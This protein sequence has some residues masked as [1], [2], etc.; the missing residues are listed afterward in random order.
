MNRTV[1]YWNSISLPFRSLI[2]ASGW[3][4]SPQPESCCCCC[5]SRRR[6]GLSLCTHSSWLPPSA[7]RLFL[8]PPL[9]EKPERL[10]RARE[11]VEGARLFRLHAP[12]PLSLFTSRAHN[13]GQTP[14][15]QLML[16]KLKSSSISLRGNR[17]YFFKLPTPSFPDGGLDSTFLRENT[18]HWT[19][20]PLTWNLS[21]L[22][23]ILPSF[24]TTWTD[25]SL[26]WGHPLIFSRSLL[27]QVPSPCI[28]HCWIIH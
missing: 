4:C 11:L 13:G 1:L 10:P 28:D 7:E 8:P 21:A 22:G 17:F 3:H 20:P 18:G 12:L 9:A 23:P 25:E 14:H 19:F 16:T 26:H 27:V 6:L 2:H 5:C 24:L 15:F